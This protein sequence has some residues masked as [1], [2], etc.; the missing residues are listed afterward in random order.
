MHTLAI[1]VGLTFSAAA[2]GQAAA[3][4]GHTLPAS[5]TVVT[6][7][8]GDVLRG[9]LVSRGETVVI[10]H[11]VLGRLTLALS[12]VADVRTMTAANAG[13]ATAAAQAAAA[14][15]PPPP[16][17]PDPVSFWKGWN[18]S[19]ALGA[20]G[21]SGNSES[22]SIRA[23][24]GLLRETSKTKTAV[25]LV[26][27]HATS[28]GST[29]N[30]NARLDARNDWLPQ[31]GAALRPFIQAAAEYD[32]FQDWDY[33]LSAAVG[34]GYELIKDDKTLL[35]P[36]VGLGLAREVG[37]TDNRLHVEGLLGVDFTYEIDERSKFFSSADSFW[38]LDSFP[39]YRLLLRAG[40]EVVIDPS[41]KLSLKLGVED[42]YDSTP[43][44]RE[45]NDFAYFVLLNYGF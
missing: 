1:I 11:P 25:G 27:S 10:E 29:S 43:D 36:R 6:L 8:N 37:G 28:D 17:P 19:I 39:D 45:R 16:A 40:Y 42:K 7:T 3:P 41:S 4:A 35:L 38:V 23:E 31:D 5:Q 21:A 20:N 18:G 13:K 34:V 30:D 22:Q 9:E 12:D 44:G 24:A 15:V 32:R 33:R 2:Q 14:K 26:Y